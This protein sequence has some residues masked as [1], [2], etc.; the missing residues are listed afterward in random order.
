L[1][2]SPP[3]SID[4]IV[5]GQVYPSLDQAISDRI[6]MRL[7]PWST[8]LTPL[9]SWQLFPRLGISDHQKDRGNTCDEPLSFYAMN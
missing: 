7:G 6:S 5:F 4:A 2:A 3:L 8:M 1:L 9:R